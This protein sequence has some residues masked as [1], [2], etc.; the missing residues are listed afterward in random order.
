MVATPQQG[1]EPSPRFSAPNTTSR[2]VRADDRR[3]DR[4]PRAASHRVLRPRLSLHLGVHEAIV[5]ER[6]LRRHEIHQRLGVRAGTAPRGVEDE[7]L[8]R[9]RQ[10]VDRPPPAPSTAAAAASP[11]SRSRRTTC[12]GRRRSPEPA[13]AGRA[14]RRTQGQRL[15]RRGGRREENAS[16]PSSDA[17]ERPE[18]R[19]RPLRRTQSTTTGR[20]V[21]GDGSAAP[22]S[23][24]P[25]RP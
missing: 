19:G 14:T 20:R 12:R 1:H 9:R 4:P 23:R 5:N 25:P 11:R 7:E 8:H 15:R 17:G 10:T 3:D 21:G 16:R 6:V 22:S 18:R 2:R 24:C 13:C